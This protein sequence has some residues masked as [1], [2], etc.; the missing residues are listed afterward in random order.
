[1]DEE[2]KAKLKRVRT[3]A[4]QTK[5]DFDDAHTRGMDRLKAHDFDGL[6]R[7]IEEERAAI[8]KLGEVIEAVR[9][10][11]RKSVGHRRSKR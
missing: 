1:M 5:R 8:D 9:P 10:R 2:L 6:F 3:L 7:A 4:A 11:T